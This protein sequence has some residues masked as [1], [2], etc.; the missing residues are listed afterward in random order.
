M[1]LKFFQRL[2]LADW[3]WEQVGLR[4]F[5]EARDQLFDERLLGETAAGRTRF[6]EELGGVRYDERH[7]S[8]DELRAHD[9]EIVRFWRQI[10]K[11]PARHFEGRAPQLQYFQYLACLWN[12]IYLR[13][14]FGDRAAL[15][16]ELNARV[17][18]FNL[19]H[20]GEPLNDYQPAE[21]DKLAFWSATGSG[22]TLLMHVHLLQYRAEFERAQKAG[23]D[24]GEALQKVILLTPSESLS[25]QHREELALSG[26]HSA[27]FSERALQNSFDWNDALTLEFSKL[28]EEAGEK[29]VAIESFNG[30]YLILVDEGHRGLS[31]TKADAEARVWKKARDRLAKDGFCYEYSATFEQV[32][33]K[34]D[35][36]I[37]QEYSRCI[38][39]DYS[40]RR[41]YDDGYGKNFPR[42]QYR[43]SQTRRCQRQGFWH[44]WR[45]RRRASGTL[46]QR[47]VAF[48]SGPNPRLR[49]R[50]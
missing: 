50:E 43:R 4:D 22:K 7:I 34:A 29:R 37:N 47:R 38:A 33:G 26:L 48:V 42:F 20:P 32:V 17:A 11:N 30:R 21:L 46:S 39:L 49:A 35:G 45:R 24:T 36:I 40:Y 41:F 25:A 8:P 6:G 31:G 9:E 18:A 3:F 44:R 13:R 23:Q 12:A 2:V 27:P 19:K 10:T 5:D 15:C 14:L 28:G 16:A 1:P